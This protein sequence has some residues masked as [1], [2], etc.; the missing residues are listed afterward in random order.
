[1]AEFTLPG[2]TD[3]VA[4]VGRTGS[5]KTVAGVWL[6]SVSRF[7]IQPFIVLD[8]KRDKLI[9]EITRAKEIGFKS[10]LPTDPGIYVL[11]PLPGQ[12]DEL[13]EWMWR[14]WAHEQTGIFVDEGYSIPQQ[15]KAWQAILTQGRSKQLPVIALSQRPARVSRH[16]FSEADFLAVFQLNHLEDRKTIQEYAPKGQL[17]MDERLPPYH[18]HWYDVKQDAAFVI[19]PVPE[20]SVILATIDAKL[21]PKRKVA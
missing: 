6:L 15:S 11:R 9:G 20:A 3:R 5:G 14:L 8:Y 21:T 10:K 13:E 4:V 2:L 18:F 16:V 19:Q 12:E 7:D 17:N 1:M